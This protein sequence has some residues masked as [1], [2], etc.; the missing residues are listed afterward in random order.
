MGEPAF[1]AAR[2]YLAFLH[3]DRAV[4]LETFAGQDGKPVLTVRE[5]T[6][7]ARTTR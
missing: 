1:V 5:L 4:S 7:L 2:R 3:G 6:E